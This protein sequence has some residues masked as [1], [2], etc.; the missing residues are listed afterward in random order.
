MALILAM[1][2]E[3]SL[4]AVQMQLFYRTLQITTANKFRI[5]ILLD[6]KRE[7]FLF[8]EPCRRSVAIILQTAHPVWATTSLMTLTHI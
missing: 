6:N 4:S 3:E 7:L 8:Y 2:S 1:F 5:A